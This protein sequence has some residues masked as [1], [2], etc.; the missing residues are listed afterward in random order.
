MLMDRDNGCVSLGLSVVYG[1]HVFL[2][3]Y[4]VKYVRVPLQES[5]TELIRISPVCLIER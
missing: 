1:F 2:S 3:D 5:L 4:S